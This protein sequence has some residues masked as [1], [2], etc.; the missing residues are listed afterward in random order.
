MRT[1]TRTHSLSL[2]HTHTY[3]NS[4]QL[5]HDIWNYNV[6]LFV[7][8]PVKEEETNPEE[9]VAENAAD[10]ETDSWNGHMVLNAELPLF[11]LQWFI[12]I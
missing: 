4:I 12:D 9:D 11:P 1:H 5:L 6:R 10:G 2:S 3:C 8:Q 7:S